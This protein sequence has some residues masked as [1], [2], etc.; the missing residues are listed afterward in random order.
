M[1]NLVCTV[2]HNWYTD[3]VKTNHSKGHNCLPH[4]FPSYLRPELPAYLLFLERRIMAR[5]AM[6]MM[7][8]MR[9]ALRS[10]MTPVA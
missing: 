7:A 1:I 9:L 5:T 8:R 3:K 6:E 2:K 4:I 10:M